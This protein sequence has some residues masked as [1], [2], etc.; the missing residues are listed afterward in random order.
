MTYSSRRN[1]LKL[2][3]GGALAAGGVATLGTT[4]FAQEF[5]VTN[6]YQNFKRG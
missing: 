1:A 5:V 6:N 4:A 2:M 3:A